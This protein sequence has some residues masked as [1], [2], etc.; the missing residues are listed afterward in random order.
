MIRYLAFLKRFP[1]TFKKLK[2]TNGL[3]I[4][5]KSL[6]VLLLFVKLIPLLLL[7]IS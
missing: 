1:D 6:S 5:A 2:L 7:L 4:F 3:G